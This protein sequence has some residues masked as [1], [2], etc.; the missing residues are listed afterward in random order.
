M[1]LLKAESKC[2]MA[3]DQNWQEQS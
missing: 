2:S 1:L 3:S